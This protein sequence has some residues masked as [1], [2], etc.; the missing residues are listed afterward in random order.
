[1]INFLSISPQQFQLFLLIL[2]RIGGVIIFAPVLGNK[3]IPIKAKIGLSLLFSFLL[4]PVVSSSVNKVIPGDIFIYGLI[5]S[6]ELSIGMIL[7]LA[8]KMIFGGVQL[9]GQYIG[10]QMGFAIVNVMDPQGS[11]QVSIIAVFENLL[12]ILIFLAINGHHWFL[13]AIIKSFQFASPV[14]FRF[15]GAIFDI[16]IKLSAEMFL[17]AIQLGAPAI[18]VA[19]LMNVAMGIIARTVPQINVFFVGFPLQIAIGLIAFAL[20]LYFFLYILKGSFIRLHGDIFTLIR[21]M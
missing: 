7:G 5:I 16:I 8:A 12:A 18:V 1:M 13:E 17:I 20:S 15:S 3:N 9:S 4:F 6:K 21:L 19:F 10:M 14:S 2:A 11:E